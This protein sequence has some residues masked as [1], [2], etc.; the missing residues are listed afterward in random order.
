MTF[1]DHGWFE[2]KIELDATYDSFGV[3]RGEIN[4]ELLDISVGSF[5]LTKPG[6]SVDI[7]LH[8]ARSSGRRH[9]RNQLCLQWS[10]KGLL[11]RTKA[12]P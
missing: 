2:G 11:G 7:S 9:C 1:G 5:R 6:Y 3:P 10:G 12:N 8:N 4:L